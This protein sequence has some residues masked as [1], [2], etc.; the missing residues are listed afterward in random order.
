MWAYH[1][2]FILCTGGRIHVEISDS[3]QRHTFCDYEEYRKH[4]TEY[5]YEV[6]RLCRVLFGQ[7]VKLAM[8]GD[9]GG[10]AS[11]GKES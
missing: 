1:G 6:I 11:I 9:R 3:Y 5:Q 7:P 8:N 2:R 4:V 10:A